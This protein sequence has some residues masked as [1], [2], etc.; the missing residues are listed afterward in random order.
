MNAMIMHYPVELRSPIMSI[1]G[2]FIYFYKKVDLGVFKQKFYH[3][4]I[5][6]MKSRD[7]CLKSS[8]FKIL[9]KKVFFFFYH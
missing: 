9:Q 8:F 5:V 1:L 2:N 6:Y 4:K 3:A 7:F